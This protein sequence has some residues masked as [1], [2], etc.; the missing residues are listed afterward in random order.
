[1]NNTCGSCSKYL[2]NKVGTQ[3]GQRDARTGRCAELS[4]FH[5]SEFGLPDGVK[6]TKDPVA[7]IVVRHT[8]QVVP[9]CPHYTR[10]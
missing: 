5:E 3:Q 7:S 4:V 9:H 1:M 10:A 8:D 6:V 2:P